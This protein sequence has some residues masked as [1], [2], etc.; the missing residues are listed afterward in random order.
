MRSLS[1]VVYTG[2]WERID[3]TGR[4]EADREGER[5]EGGAGRGQEKHNFE[6]FTRYRRNAA[7]KKRGTAGKA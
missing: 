6:T 2:G 1:S 5:R 3:K 4:D 7:Q